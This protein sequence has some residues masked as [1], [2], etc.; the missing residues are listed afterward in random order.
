MKK[1]GRIAVCV[2]GLKGA[3]FLEGLLKRDV[4]IGLIV[5]YQ[6]ADDRSGSFE[7]TRALAARYS[8]D[9]QETR[10]PVLQAGDLTFLVGWQYLLPAVTPTT[11]VFHDSILP[12]YRGFAPTVTALINGDREIG[13]T[14]LTPTNSVDAGPIIAQRA[15]PV[16]YPVKIQAA[17]EQQ[18]GLM[19]DIAVGI[20]EQWRH[21]RLSS[22]PQPESGATYSIW[23]DDS[24]YEIDWTDSADEIERFVNAV[25]HPYAGARTTVGGTEIIRIV[26]VTALPDL[27]FEIRD[28]G[29]IWELEDGRATVICGTGMLK[30]ERCC[31][32]DGSEFIF[33]RLRERLGFSSSVLRDPPAA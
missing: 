5:T 23:R 27:H 18:A 21:G 20:I 30:I 6:Q 8:I 26:E 25:G 16:S 28:A 9:M 19:I 10:H 33:Q 4:R 22:I 2:V 12:R 24:D 32:E 1:P 13:V 11:I 17:L 14:A 3:T 29:K 31:R 15:F 7:R